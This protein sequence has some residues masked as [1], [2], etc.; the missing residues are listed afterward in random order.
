MNEKLHVDMGYVLAHSAAWWNLSFQWARTPPLWMV[1]ELPSHQQLGG[2]RASEL[3]VMALPQ[4]GRG[5]GRA[6]REMAPAAR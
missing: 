4:A 1:E 3:H 5:V 2:Y 6:F